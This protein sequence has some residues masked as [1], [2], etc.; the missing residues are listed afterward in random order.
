MGL[1]A[2]SQPLSQPYSLHLRLYEYRTWSMALCVLSMAIQAMF[3]PATFPS[4]RRSGR[5]ISLIFTHRDILTVRL[6]AAF[7]ASQSKPAWT[8]LNSSDPKGKDYQPPPPGRRSS[9]MKC[10]RWVSESGVFSLLSPQEPASTIS[11][12][13]SPPLTLFRLFT[14]SQ[15]RG[16]GETLERMRK[17][18]P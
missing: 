1:P 11:S 12:P 17:T 9:L 14:F 15:C 13:F 16:S 4:I 3:P 5:T 10:V 8:R 7:Q 6:L 2:C 18:R